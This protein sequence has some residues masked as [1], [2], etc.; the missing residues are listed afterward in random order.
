MTYLASTGRMAFYTKEGQPAYGP[1][2]VSLTTEGDVSMQS[3]LAVDRFPVADANGNVNYS[4]TFQLPEGV[5]AQ[6]ID[7]GVIVQHGISKLFGD[8]NQYDGD[9]VISLDPSLPL[10]A[11]IPATC[12][13]IMA[14]AMMPETGTG[15]LPLALLAAPLLLL[16][17]GLV[18]RRYAVLA[19]R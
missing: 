1:V 6:D 17:A 13:K 10:E 15:D 16:A 4:R 5:T 9:K 19:R 11:T 18:T 12:G 8:P 7:K 3:G 14:A 2:M